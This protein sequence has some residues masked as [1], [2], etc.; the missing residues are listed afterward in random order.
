VVLG[1]TGEGPTIEPEERCELV[2]RSVNRALGVPIV[3][4]TG[5]NSTKAAVRLTEE[6]V[7]LGADAVLVVVPYYNK[8]TPAGLRTHFEAVATA[9]KASP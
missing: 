9:A 5:S 4:G 2:K 8:P 6:A 3:V 7:D 1:S